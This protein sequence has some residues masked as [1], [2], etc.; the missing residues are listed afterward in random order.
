MAA[1]LKVGL[2]PRRVR[3]GDLV[4]QRI[5]AFFLE[6]GSS[7]VENKKSGCEQLSRQKRLKFNGPMALPAGLGQVLLAPQRVY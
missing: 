1:R 2:R 5:D 3:R 4:L 7:G 6:L